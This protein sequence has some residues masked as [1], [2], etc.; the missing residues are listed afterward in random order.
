MPTNILLADDHCILRQGLRRILESYPDFTVVAEAGSGR[1]AVE[2]AREHQPDVAIVDIAMGELNGI[3]AT[4]QII[5]YS[6]RTAVIILSMHG[7]ERYIVRALNAGAK[8]YLLKDSV[9]QDLV[10]AIQSVCA[11]RPFFS[12]AIRQVLAERQASASVPGHVEDR[13]DLL[14]G[15]ERQ[16]YQLLAEGRSNKDIASLLVLSLHTVETHRTR[17]MEKMN[18]HSAAE[19]VLSAVRRGIVR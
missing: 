10:Q 15:R 9:E 2:L 6:P 12:P 14:T 3:D 16:I 8:G 13:Y 17:I 4:A 5:R 18:V 1:Q 7:D 11:D 19:L